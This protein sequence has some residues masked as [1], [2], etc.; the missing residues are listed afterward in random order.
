VILTDDIVVKNFA[1][2]LR[3]GIPSRDFANEDV[4]SSDDVH[5]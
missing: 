5:A 3:V 1:Y 2:L 4:F